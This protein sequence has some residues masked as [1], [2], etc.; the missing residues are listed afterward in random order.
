[1]LDDFRRSSVA[2]A[3]RKRFMGSLALAIGL[4]ASLAAGL[5]AATANISPPIE[6]ELRPVPWHP[7]EKPAPPAV[8]PDNPE[9]I[10]K[11]PPRPHRTPDRLATTLSAE[12]NDPLPAADQA[13]PDGA[14]TAAVAAADRPVVPDPPVAPAPVIRPRELPGHRYTDLEY[15]ARAMRSGISGIVVVEFD[16]LPDGRVADPRIVS[17]PVEFHATVLAAARAWRFEPAR[18]AGKP[19]R[20]RL[21]KRIVFRLEDA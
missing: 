1:M 5:I 4:Y 12:S 19:V 17:G 9:K 11:H 8:A 7:R 18:Q 10:A 15:P 20:Y 6:I 14:A 13:E 2:A 21:T 16:V 3:P